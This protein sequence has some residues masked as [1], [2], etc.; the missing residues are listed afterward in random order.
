MIIYLCSCGFATD[1]LP[2]STVTWTS[3]PVI[4]SSAWCATRGHVLPVLRLI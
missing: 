2:G 4:G 3:I 1:D